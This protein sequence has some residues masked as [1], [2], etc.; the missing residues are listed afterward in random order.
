MVYLFASDQSAVYLTL[1][2]GVTDLNAELGRAAARVELRRRAE[3]RAGR[4]SLGKTSGLLPS[5]MVSASRRLRAW[6]G[7]EFGTIAYKRYARWEVKLG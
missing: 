6:A 2:Q 5:I 7:A 4:L 1:N 3:G